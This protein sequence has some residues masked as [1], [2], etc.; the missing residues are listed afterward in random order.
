MP[1]YGFQ[2]KID[3]DPQQQVTLCSSRDREQG[4][5]KHLSFRNSKRYQNKIFGFTSD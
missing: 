4:Q 1:A 5:K 2:I 3:F